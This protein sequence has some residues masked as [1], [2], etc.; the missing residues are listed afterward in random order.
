MVLLSSLQSGY[1]FHEAPSNVL[2]YSTRGL[3]FPKEQISNYCIC[4]YAFFSGNEI[5]SLKYPV[6]SFF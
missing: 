3:G 6:K 2:T 1:S 4:K 5:G